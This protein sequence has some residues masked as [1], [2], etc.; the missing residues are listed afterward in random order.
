MLFTVSNSRYYNFILLKN[1][2]KKNFGIQL[3]FEPK[4]KKQNI[5]IY[6]FVCQEVMSHTTHCFVVLISFCLYVYLIIHETA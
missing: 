1:P 3:G 2:Q 5:I 6:K 4:T